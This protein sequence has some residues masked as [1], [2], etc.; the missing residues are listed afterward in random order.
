MACLP[1]DNNFSTHFS[2]F[3]LT[4]SIDYRVSILYWQQLL[5]WEKQ[6]INEIYSIYECVPN[7][8][9]NMPEFLK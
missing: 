8:L 1:T 2:Q 4:G 6:T 3:L 5:M 7:F 9:S